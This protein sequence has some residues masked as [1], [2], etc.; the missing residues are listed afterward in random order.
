VL[1]RQGWL[2]PG[3]AERATPKPTQS[4]GAFGR[5]I[6]RRRKE[7]LRGGEWRA[8]RAPPRKRPARSPART[9]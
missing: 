2:T 1:D 9:P 4:K 5:S 3:Q 7:R 6:K 8:H